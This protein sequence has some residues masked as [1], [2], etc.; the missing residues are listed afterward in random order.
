MATRDRHDLAVPLLR[1]NFVL[2]VINGAL[3]M[4]GVRAADPGTVVPLLVLRLAGAE[5]AVGLTAAVQEVGRVLTQVL[6]ARW[7]DPV[8]QKRPVYIWG[9]VARVI[10]LLT[11]TGALCLGV[12][13]DPR[14][15]L[16]VLLAS[17]FV[18][19]VASGVCELAWTDITARSVPSARRG[20]L[21]TGRRVLGLI[22]A[23]VVAAP[24]VDHFLDP[25]TSYRFPA[26]YG[27]LFLVSTMGWAAA[28]TVFAL[29][30][31][32][33]PH[34]A[35]R[36]LTLRQHLGRGLRILRRDDTYRSLLGLRLL[37]GL[38]GAVP[39]FFIAFA[40]RGLGLG[41]RW[42][43]L[44][45]AVRTVSEILGSV[46]F[47]RVSDRTG[48]RKV[49]VIS[50]W[51]ATL[52]FAVAS[53]SALSERVGGPAGAASQGSILLLGAAFCGLGL[54][55]PAR[56]MGEFNYMLDIAPALKR[57]SY[58]GFA[59]AFLLPL[60]LVPIGVGWLA[61]RVGYLPLFV[62]ATVVSALAIPAAMRLQEPRDELAEVHQEAAETIVT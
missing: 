55:A 46:V 32:P 2:N 43:A 31:E 33:A 23:V 20:S 14:G 54:L 42:A 12:G 59:N 9:S 52:T 34:A 48:N 49:I 37:T 6:A 18:L 11:A 57:G 13:R 16:V 15:V 1:R 38:A 25:R 17:L 19:M 5:W 8:E 36:R 35:R 39:V 45:L 50:T 29:G 60:S 4:V 62:L 24:L 47:G 3:S 40:S 51:I 21:M 41:E 61:P 56:E 44:F 58:I 22:L 7:L 28:W 27:M 10:A 30:R 26:N 53:L